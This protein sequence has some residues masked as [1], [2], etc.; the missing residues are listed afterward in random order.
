MTKRTPRSDSPEPEGP[1]PDELRTNDPQ[2]DVQD[3][4]EAGDD[5]AVVLLDEDEAPES[6]PRLAGTPK[7][8]S[9]KK[10]RSKGRTQLMRPRTLTAEQRLLIL[11]FVAAE[12]AAGGRLS[13]LVGS[14]PARST[15]GSG[16]SPTT[17]RREAPRTGHRAPIREAA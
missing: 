6:R 11:D 2:E 7:G 8:G 3:L 10:P 13:P 9:F 15:S 4:A 1:D 12:Q 16:C 5:E 17:A 14:R